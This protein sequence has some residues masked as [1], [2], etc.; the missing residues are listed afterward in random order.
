MSSKKIMV[1]GGTGFYGRQVVKSLLDMG[2]PVKV[3]TRSAEKARQTLGEKVTIFEG[4]VTN[5]SAIVNSLK[6]VKAIVLCLSAVTFKL[7]RKRRQ[8]ERDA[9][10]DIMEEAEKAGIKRLVYF[11]GYEMRPEV[12]ERLKIPDFGAI[13][14]EMENKIKTSSFN[15]T[16][17]GAPPSFE[18]FFAFLR[19]GQLAVPGGVKN[20]IPTASPQDVGKIAA[21]T[22]LRNDL[23]GKRIKLPG[24]KAYS[25]P[26]VAKMMSEIT[27][28]QIK[29]MA[30]PITVIRI[31]SIL[32]YPIT[33]FPRFLYKSLKLLNN[34]P[35]DLV[36]RVEDDHQFL[37]D[38]FDYEP[39][40]LEM[41]IKEKL[42]PEHTEDF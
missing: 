33:P 39:V 19:K 22:I 12:L 20:P 35:K 31:V 42:L 7:I 13:M 28:Q 27:G 29:H 32:A 26:E 1:F 37:L 34:F 16:I 40:S 23:S 11:S 3:M 18:I 21:Q 10:L 9:V 15:W 4:D 30:I 41:A 36:E 24:P 2:Q 8:I 5:H 17:L 38:N 25:F 14:I 6:G